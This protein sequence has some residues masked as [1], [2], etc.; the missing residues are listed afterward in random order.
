[1]P[2]GTHRARDLVPAVA[3]GLGAFLLGQGDRVDVHVLAEPAKATAAVCN[4]E[5]PLCLGGWDFCLGN[6]AP[7]GS[8]RASTI[9]LSPGAVLGDGDEVE[10]GTHCWAC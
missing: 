9:T 2:H 3:C 5:I 1:M 7:E 8:Y 6:G 4:N 10:S